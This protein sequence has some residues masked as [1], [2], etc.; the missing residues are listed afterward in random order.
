MVCCIKENRCSLLFWSECVMCW[1]VLDDAYIIS[2]LLRNCGHK[3]GFPGGSADKES[4][5]NAGDS[6][7][8]GLIPGSGIFPGEGNGNPLQYSCLENPMDREAWQ[9][10]V[11]G[12]LDTIEVIEH[13]VINVKERERRIEYGKKA[14][15]GT[16]CWGS[17]I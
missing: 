4:A 7:D 12:E 5:C 14:L 9:A 16:F 8:L 3:W 10:K 15:E 2:N 1:P 13:L 6:G 11:R 17:F